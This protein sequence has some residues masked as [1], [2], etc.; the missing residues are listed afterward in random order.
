MKYRKDINFNT[1]IKCLAFLHIYTY[2]VIKKSFRQYLF[3]LVRLKHIA[4]GD[5]ID[6]YYLYNFVSA[7]FFR[8]SETLLQRS[9]IK[10]RAVFSTIKHFL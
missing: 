2:K 1:Y 10:S 3:I 9:T 6:S 4:T 5:F 8:I 7:V